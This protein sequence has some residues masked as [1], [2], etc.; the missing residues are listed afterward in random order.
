MKVS[1][2]I[3][4]NTYIDQYYLGE[5]AVCY[6]IEDGERVILFDT[7]YS[8][9]FL[10]NAARMK[11]DLGRV[12]DIVLSHGHNDHTG[13]LPAFFERFS[14][15]VWI[16]AHPGVFQPKR[17]RG[18]DIGI[19]LPLDR[20]PASAE[21]RLTKKPA[22]VSE[23]CWFLGEIPRNYAF[24]KNRAFGET[25]GSCGCWETDALLDDSSLALVLAQGVFV[26]TGCAHA[27]ICNTVALAKAQTGAARVLGVLGGFHLFEA[28]TAL[29]QTIE[30]LRGLGLESAYPAHC[31][32]LSVKSAFLSAFDTR[33]VG[34]GMTLEL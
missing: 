23:H 27:G 15:S 32:S 24:E 30:T 20:L 2:L 12:T 14:Q 28:G 3:D 19:P 18:Q 10:E 11:I 6:L 7:G 31:T 22:A 29:D 1:V 26:V 16:Y 34:V 4:N 5:P 13:G 9:A 21:A 25:L 33:E 8:A 17:E